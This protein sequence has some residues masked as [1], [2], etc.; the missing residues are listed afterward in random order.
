[1]KK[2]EFENQEKSDNLEKLD[3]KNNN[4]INLK[5]ILNRI[6]LRNV[7]GKIV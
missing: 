1:M 7:I 6:R 3:D 5:N 4:E 2:I